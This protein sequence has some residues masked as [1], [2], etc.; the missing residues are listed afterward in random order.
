MGGDLPGKHA[1]V[2]SLGVLPHGL[3]FFFFFFLLSVNEVD[4]GLL[5]IS[6]WAFNLLSSISH[7]ELPSRERY[8]VTFNSENCL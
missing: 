2:S 4:V 8:S 1:V 5:L 6:C 7:S 3:S